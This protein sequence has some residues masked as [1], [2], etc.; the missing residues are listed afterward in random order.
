MATFSCDA[1]HTL[2]GGSTIR[3][4]GSDGTWSGSDPTCPIDGMSQTEITLTSF[5]T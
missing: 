1:G 5:Y 3:M 2:T 4:C